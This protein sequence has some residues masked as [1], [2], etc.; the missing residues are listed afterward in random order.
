M[1]IVRLL[2]FSYFIIR[3]TLSRGPYFHCGGPSGLFHPAF[4]FPCHSH[5]FWWTDI[6]SPAGLFFR[7]HLWVASTLFWCDPD[8]L[9]IHNTCSHLLFHALPTASV[10]EDQSRFYAEFFSKF[11]PGW[12]RCMREIVADTLWGYPVCS[13]RPF[14]YFEGD[15]RLLS[16]GLC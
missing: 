3:P 7:A 1:D 15:R 16:L 12:I 11:H 8:F 10:V 14:T 5:T 13:L 4:L 6:T 2:S 9:Y